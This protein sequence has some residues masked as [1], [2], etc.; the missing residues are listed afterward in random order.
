VYD[1]GL[2]MMP[3]EEAPE[4]ERRLTELQSQ[5]NRLSLSVHLW[6]ERQDRLFEQRLTDWNAVEARA[7]KDATDRLQELQRTIEHEWQELRQRE[8]PIQQFRQLEMNLSERLS[9]LSDEVHAAVLELRAVAAERPHTLQTTPPSW[10]LDDVVRLHNQIRES[11]EAVETGD[12]ALATRPRLQMSEVPAG[13]SE[14]LN[15]LEQ[16]IND[17]QSEIREAT[18]R[19]NRFSRLG[20]A[21]IVV[22]AVGAAAS[23]FFVNR[24]RHQV[25]AATVRV[26][27]AEQQAQAAT[28][29][30]TE[31]ISAARDAA[32]QQIA[33]ARELAVKAQTISDVLAAP[34]LA[35]YNLVGGDQNVSYSAQALW[36]RSRGLVFSGSRLPAP[37]AN[38]TYQIWL[39]TTG[40]PM[41]AG[42][43]VPDASGRVSLAMTPPARVP[44]LVGVSV[45][46]E[47]TGGAERPTG[48]TVLTRAQPPPPPLSSQLP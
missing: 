27:E 14:R 36:S 26:S 44:P 1:L 29:S 2:K 28:R 18:E 47:K 38:S 3:A 33:E 10:P 9:E 22:L 35:R 8:D 39:L 32:A 19:G 21:A 20:W 31:Q 46:I 15:T 16:A 4:L 34:D 17:G 7:Q 24:L 42:T 12:R 25:N 40:E 43:F 41:S 11:D 37:P 23:G 5:I 30:A 13:L 48:R 6:Q 45:S